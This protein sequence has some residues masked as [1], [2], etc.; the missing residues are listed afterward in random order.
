MRIGIIGTGKIVE[1]FLDAL[2]EVDNV[3]CTA[4]YSRRMETGM[5]LAKKFRVKQVYTDYNK[6]LNDEEVNFVYIA[7]PNSMHYEYA[8]EALNNDKNVICEKPFT[9]TA[10]EAKKLIDLAKE[11][12]LF[13][14]EAI[15]TLHLP[16]YKK[17][18]EVAKTLRN[19][20]LVQCNFSQYSS[21]Y[22]KLLK[23][24]ITNAFNPFFSGGAL[25]DINIY[26]LHFVIGLFG[27]ANRVN[28]LANKGENGI[29]TSGIAT[30][31]YDDFLCT[32]V[33]AKDSNSS[34]FAIIQGENGYIKLNG[35]T[36]QCLS[37]E[38]EIDGKHE[39]YNEQKFSNRMIYEIKEFLEL[40]N[41]KDFEKSYRLL[42]HSLKVVESAVEARMDAGIVFSADSN[43]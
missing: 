33:G 34:C 41:N 27:K 5:T 11:K 39:E 30:L 12:N 31:E 18:K 19:I 36:N 7:S 8:L 10:R 23:G 26:N 9:S 13:I 20:K 16:N 22:D 42:E 35:A 25:Q 4:I 1:E 14:F 37:F 28:Y 43:I 32:C 15:T 29:D 6:L 3:E 17:L 21:R 40:Y 2:N 24:E 38:M